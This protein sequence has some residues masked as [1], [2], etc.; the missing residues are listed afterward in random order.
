MSVPLSDTARELLRG[1]IDMHVH[2]SPDPYAARR[3]DA[4][5]LAL[6]A[7]DAGMAGLVLKSHEYPTGP[8]AWA[9][10]T[11]IEGIALYGAVALDHAA[12]GLNVDAVDVA[13]RT[14]ARVVWM[15]TFDAAHWRE[16]RP[17]G[18][19]SKRDGIR[20]VDGDG[21]LVPAVREILDLVAD[22]GAVLASGHLSPGETLALMREARQRG[23]PSIVTHASFWTPV[24]VQRELVAMGAF[25]E[26][27]AIAVQGE[28]GDAVF[29][30]IAAQVRS[31]GTDHVV[32]STDLG[33]AANPD[34]PEGFGLWVDRFLGAGFTEAEVGL[35]VR[36]NPRKLLGE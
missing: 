6:G 19:H 13:L 26:Q 15:P 24:Q 18:A 34:P 16:F 3:M 5:Q 31:A 23:I 35:M 32:L 12:G 28:G 20:V 9:L 11:E 25:I 4:R 1:A 22:A 7:R 33:Q 36:G 17:G 30:G 8:L 21:R 14:G 29:D 2:A 27:C 10:G